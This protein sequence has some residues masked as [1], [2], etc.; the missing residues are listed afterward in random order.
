MKK[1]TLILC[2]HT[3][4]GELGAGGLISRLLE[5]KSE[6]QWMV[7]SSARASVPNG[8]EDDTL[9]KEFSN[10]M[11]SLKISEEQYNLFDYKVRR[12]HENRQDILE[13]LIKIRNE[14]R[15]ELVLGPSLNDFHQDHQ[16]V[17]N[18]MVRAFKSY[19]SILCYELPWNHIK[20]ENQF[21]I[22][23]EERHIKN[24]LAMLS[25]YKSQVVKERN[26][27][28][29]EFIRGL[30][31]TRGVQINSNYAEAFEVLKWIE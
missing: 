28:S 6:L 8:Y 5:E 3:D 9:A 18:E 25:H 14:F 20:F 22:K 30:A 13:S 1:R 31:T 23:L 12:L 19:C 24:K 21:F 17:A 16:V 27:F 2:P 10:V 26:Y 29:E 11:K 15:P 4:D 7:F